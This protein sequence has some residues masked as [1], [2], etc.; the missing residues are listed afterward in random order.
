MKKLLLIAPLLMLSACMGSN[1]HIDLGL[2]PAAQVP[3][4]PA[5]LAKK[6]ERLPDLKGKTLAERELEDSATDQI[7][8]GVAT[9]LNAIIDA[10]GCVKTALKNRTDANVCLNQITK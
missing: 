6:A 7:Y 5:P 3:D 1:Q 4:L 10:W 9:Q 2:A 8:N